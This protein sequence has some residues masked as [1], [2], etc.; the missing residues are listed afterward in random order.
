MVLR[1]FDRLTRKNAPWVFLK[2]EPFRNIAAL[3]LTAV[4]VAIMAFGK[5]ARK[6]CGRASMRRAEEIPLMQ[7]P[8]IC[9]TARAVVS[10][11]ENWHGTGLALGAERPKRSC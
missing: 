9:G 10:T 1:A 7:V 4:L 8:V 5:E 3:E 11:E 2:G 6:R